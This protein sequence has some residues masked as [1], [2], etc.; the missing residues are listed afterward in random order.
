MVMM[1][2]F[3]TIGALVWV[4]ASCMAGESEAEKRRVISGSERAV[5]MP[6]GAA[7][8]QTRQAA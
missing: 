3:V 5:P 1:I 2:G 4:L 7:R 8:G 6:D